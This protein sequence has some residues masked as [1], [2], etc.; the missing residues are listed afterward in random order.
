MA[1]PSFLVA[2]VYTSSTT[3]NDIYLPAGDWID[4][5]DS[6][7]KSGPTTIDGYDAPLEKLPMFVRA[8]AIVPMWPDMHYAGE[9]P[10]DVLTFDIFPS[11]E[12]SFTL[13]EDD[14]RTREAL[15]Q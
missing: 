2:P 8:G 11:G 5:W 10:L 14:G 7:L 1:G 15:E 12:S 6:S 3:R 9:K 4:Y 13:Y